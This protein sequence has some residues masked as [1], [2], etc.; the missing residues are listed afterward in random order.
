MLYKNERFEHIYTH[1]HTYCGRIDCK[2]Q[3]LSQT[4]VCSHKRIHTC[5]L[6]SIA[7][8]HSFTHAPKSVAHVYAMMS[9]S[10]YLLNSEW[11]T[12]E[13][14]T[15]AVCEHCFSC[16]DRQKANPRWKPAKRNAVARQ[17]S[18]FPASPEVQWSFWI[19]FF[20]LC[21]HFTPQEYRRLAEFT[22][23]PHRGL[24]LIC[25]RPV[26]LKILRSLTR[27]VLCT[28]LLVISRSV[29]FLFFFFF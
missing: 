7:T 9:T 11:M 23:S 14:N 22:V 17:D 21:C 18:Y 26:A 4:Q 28:C 29:L 24:H 25:Q 15:N 16:R 10:L 6:I 13:T 5:I 1:P 20:F 12:F 3:S 8:V 2:T 27:S 19:Y